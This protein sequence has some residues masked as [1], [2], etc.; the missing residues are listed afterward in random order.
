M[1]NYF[2]CILAGCMSSSLIGMNFTAPQA[3]D[4]VC[5]SPR[6]TDGLGIRTGISSINAEIIGLYLDTL[7]TYKGPVPAQALS[8]SENGHIARLTT[9]GHVAID[10]YNSNNQC[11]TT[12][13]T[14]N[15][16]VSLVALSSTGKYLA[17]YKANDSCSI[18]KH[19][20]ESYKHVQDL[21]LHEAHYDVE[22]IAFDQEDDNS[23]LITCAI[24]HFHGY[25][26]LVSHFEK[27][28]DE[29]FNAT[30][31]VPI[32][33]HTGIIRKYGPHT[34]VLESSNV[35]GIYTYLQEQ[36]LQEE[37]EQELTLPT[38]SLVQSLPMN[39]QEDNGSY[40]Q[41][42]ACNAKQ[43]VIA[44]LSENGTCDVF[45]RQ[46]DT[47]DYCHQRIAPC[48]SVPKHIVASYVALNN[49]GN[50]IAILSHESHSN[51]YYV[52]TVKYSHDRKRYGA[53]KGT[54]A[55][56][57]TDN[58]YPGQVTFTS[59]DVVAVPFTRH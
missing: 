53:R 17:V 14:T 48:S 29:P 9:D 33:H 20:Q 21:P 35:P 4:I 12:A 38:L 56:Q 30:L 8:L 42:I 45:I 15:S 44:C 23:L 32:D 13:L 34:F 7:T 50:M 25:N 26:Q 19:D 43:G 55:I 54:H 24:Q 6:F 1:N 22:E 39:N 28:H 16:P 40:L 47:H 59:N 58:S 2:I 41:D 51:N 31:H 36:A 37:S 3:D 10:R 11:V 49:V 57:S 5:V 46:N 18:F 27:R 52:E